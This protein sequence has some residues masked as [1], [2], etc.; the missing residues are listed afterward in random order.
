MDLQL[1]FERVDE[2]AN[3]HVYASQSTLVIVSMIND[4]WELKAIINIRS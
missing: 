2:V 4:G 3:I 1:N